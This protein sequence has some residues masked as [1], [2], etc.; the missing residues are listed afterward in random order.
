MQQN[1]PMEQ[2]EFGGLNFSDNPAYRP[3][4][5]AK[6]CNN[7]RIMPGRNPWLRLHG[8]RKA[9]RYGA[10]GYWSQ[11]H[12]YRH[13]DQP[14]YTYQLGL[15][16]NAGVCNWQWL[17]MGYNIAPI[18]ILTVNGTYPVN[19]RSPIAN[20]RQKV[21]MYNGLGTSDSVNGNRTPFTMFDPQ[22]SDLSTNWN[23]LFGL[24]PYENSTPTLSTP[25][26]D[27]GGNIQIADRLHFW[28]GLSSGTGHYSNVIYVGEL[29]DPNNPIVDTDLLFS[30][31][32]G[33]IGAY[34]GLNDQNALSL[35]FYVS[36]PGA[37]S[38]HT[39][40][41][42]YLMTDANTGAPI[43]YNVEAAKV[44]PT[45][46]I[47]DFVA[48]IT[49]EMPTLNDPPRPMRWLAQVGDRYYGALMAGGA[50]PFAV[51]NRDMTS[52]V[53][54]QSPKDE[55]QALGNPE[56][57]WPPDHKSETPTGEVPIWGELAPDGYRL[58][59][60]TRRGTF[61][62]EEAAD[63][64]HE[65]TSLST[66]HGLLSPKTIASRTNHG[67]LFITQ[68]KQV[69]K[70]EGD[71]LDIISSDYDSYLRD[72]EIRFC[73]HVLDPA[74]LIDRYEIY[75][76]NGTGLIHDFMTG[77]AYTIDNCDYTAGITIMGWE[78]AH[79]D[80]PANPNL[81]KPHY[82]VAKQHIYTQA[83]QPEDGLEKTRN[84]TFVDDENIT[85]DQIVGTY[86]TQWLTYGDQGLRKDVNYLDIKGDVERVGVDWWANGLD[87]SDPANKFSAIPEPIAQEG[88]GPSRKRFKLQQNKAFLYRYRFTLSGPPDGSVGDET[89][90][91]PLLRDLGEGE[92]LQK[93]LAAI[94]SV[95]HH[96]SS[97]G[98]N[99]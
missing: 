73:T 24:L 41:I 2:P 33:I 61:L 42:G 91:H 79:G 59:V 38:N 43:S 34:A 49:R 48:D 64:I 39:K 52:I 87:A 51:A 22:Y 21:V 50:G 31:L 56:E 23:Y 77:Y 98:G 66:A 28:I 35:I 81:A 82:W 47:T 84:E 75:F 86:D 46:S 93:F 6:T 57:S 63:R 88:Y 74:N 55:L 37:P 78:L 10:A 97:L 8:G 32:D 18:T 5:S 69:A 68:L 96:V 7:F 76:E 16:I 30:G 58:L 71:R 20:V 92:A 44:T 67:T 27:G 3:T 19:N 94:V 40:S 1:K 70:V 60:W 53:Y 26:P 45:F 11:F 17:D 83:G 4:T 13:Q 54:S 15:N 90:T 80:T 9:R 14:G 29:G 36:L 72:K 85:K 12:E 99:R 95:E 25:N 62:V 65:W 89:D